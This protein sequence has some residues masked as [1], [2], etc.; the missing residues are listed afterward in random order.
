MS[1][2][3]F[4][5]PNQKKFNNKDINKIEATLITKDGFSKMISIKEKTIKSIIQYPILKNDISIKDY[6]GEVTSNEIP[7]ESLYVTK[8]FGLFNYKIVQQSNYGQIIA[9]CVYKEI[10]EIY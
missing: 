6:A 3:F 10:Y 9:F 4:K 2:K 8:K 5:K 7:T 1:F